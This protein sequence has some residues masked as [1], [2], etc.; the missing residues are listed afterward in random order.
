MG[1]MMQAFYWD[2]PRVDGREFQWWNYVCGQVPAL[3]QAGFTSLWL[4]PVHKAAN[5]DGPRSTLRRAAMRS[6]R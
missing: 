3:A 6:M 2:C 4:P 5:L 1:V